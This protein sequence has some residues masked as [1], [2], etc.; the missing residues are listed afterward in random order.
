[1]LGQGQSLDHEGV[2]P[3]ALSLEVRPVTGRTD[4]N[5]ALFHFNLRKLSPQLLDPRIQRVGFS[6]M[7]TAGR[8]AG[9]GL[10]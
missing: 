6:P 2:A 3:L 7:I 8:R 5:A 9:S 1:M 10:Y 4:F